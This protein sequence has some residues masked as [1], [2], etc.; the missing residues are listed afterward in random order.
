[1][2][3]P[4]RAAELAALP[5]NLPPAEAKRLIEAGKAVVID[6]RTP[7]EYAAGR[8]EKAGANL[9][10]YAADFKDRLAKLDKSALYIIYCRS[11]KRSGLAL[12]IMKDLGFSD[13]HDI[14]G[15][16]IAW[17]EAGLPVVK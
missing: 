11:G 16:I 2:P 7:Q 8:L 9:D 10:Y 15:G 13:A 5:A 17:T 12:G 1:M 14:A 3:A 4:E 6:I